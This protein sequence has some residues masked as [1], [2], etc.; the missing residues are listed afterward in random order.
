MDNEDY[1]VG[2]VDGKFCSFQQHDVLSFSAFF[3]VVKE[4]IRRDFLEAS[5]SFAL[6]V[7]N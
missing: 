4:K 5:G 6:A 1:K 2:D 7:F 3:S